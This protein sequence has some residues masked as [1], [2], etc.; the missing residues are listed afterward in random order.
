MIETYLRDVWSIDWDP[1]DVNGIDVIRGSSEPALLTAEA[2]PVRSISPGDIATAWT[3]TAGVPRVNKHDGN[4]RE[5]SLILHEASELVECPRVV[6]VTL[7]SPNRYPLAD[8]LQIL[9][10]YPAFGVLRL[11]D[12][13]LGDHVVDIGCKPMLLSTSLPEQPVSGLGS[14]ALKPTPLLRISSP[15]SVK[16]SPDVCVSISI[17]S[18]V[19][20]AKVDTKIL[21]GVKRLRLRGVDSSCKIE[22][23]VS[24]EEVGLPFDTF[25]PLLLVGPI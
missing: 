24:E 18:D 6:Y 25:K 7:A 8:T 17:Y 14:P 21:L 12:D 20:D 22:Y 23:A 2:I 11:R 3:G 4:P 13:P 5:S 9:E 19:L 1:A 15:E 16:M 10:G